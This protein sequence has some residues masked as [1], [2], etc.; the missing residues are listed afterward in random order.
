MPRFRPY[1]M[2][3]GALLGQEVCAFQALVEM[4][5]EARSDLVVLIHGDRDCANVLDKPGFA[6]KRL[7]RRVFSTQLT[8]TDLVAGRGPARLAE[9]LDV[10]AAELRPPSILVLTT[11]S[12]AMVGD[13]VMRVAADATERLGLPV[14]AWRTHGLVPKSPAEMMDTFYALMARGAR[15]VPH[16]TR[17]TVS[18]VGFEREQGP[19]LRAMLAEL[20][21]RV[22]LVLDEQ[23]AAADFARLGQAALTVH[24]GPNL[25]LEFRR[26]CEAE[27]GT[28]SVEVPLPV[29]VASTDTFLARIAEAAGVPPPRIEQALGYERRRA[30]A[31][32]AAFRARHAGQALR[33]GCNVGSQRAYATRL[34]AA[35]GLVDLPF[36]V[37]LGF[38][39]TVFVQG[40]DDPANRERVARVLAD[41]GAPPRFVIFRDPGAL[42]QVLR[43]H[44]VELFHGAD[45]LHHE[46]VAAAV[47]FLRLLPAAFGQGYDEVPA[48][49]ARLEHLLGSDYFDRLAGPTPTTPSGDP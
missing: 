38:E 31:A 20:G 3:P 11:C 27:L 48:A 5:A 45:F 35:E 42:A 49:V 37:E 47:P 6:A 9:A 41:V 39:P 32:I 7:H 18:L 33:V 14:L 19:A 34:L 30:V 26:L 24:P 17:S 22:E 10:L 8:D 44:P 28:R 29:G 2:Y 46:V 21:L 36:F 23:S 25:L 1:R 43:E 40:P 15:R 13:D 12:T 4:I 16:V